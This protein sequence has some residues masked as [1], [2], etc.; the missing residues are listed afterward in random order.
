MARPTVSD[1]RARIAVQVDGCWLWTGPLTS[2]GYGKH[3]IDGRHVLAHRHSY[4]LTHGPIGEGLVLLHSCDV[5]RCINPAHL[6]PGTQKENAIDRARKGRG[7][8]QTPRPNP[9]RRWW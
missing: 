5:R 1:F 2:S 3:Y 7:Y 6:T 9:D 8:R 4:E